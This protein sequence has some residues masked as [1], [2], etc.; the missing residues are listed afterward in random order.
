MRR[1]LPAL[2]AV[3]EPLALL[4]VGAAAGLTLLPDA[5]SYDD[6]DHHVPGRDRGAP[7]LTCTPTGPVPLPTRVPVVAWR[8]GIDLNPLD[9][10]DP[11]RRDVA[12]VSAVAREGDRHQRLHG[13][14]ATAARHRPPSTAGTSSTTSPGSPPTPR[15]ARPWSSITRRSWP[16]STPTGAAPSPPRYATST[17][18]GCPTRPRRRR[19]TTPPHTRVPQRHLRPDPRR[20][21]TARIHRPPRHLDRVGLLTR[22]RPDLVGRA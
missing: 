19:T 11:R 16:T 12:G 13:A 20:Q 7:R 6:A 10:A 5:Y 14:L 15:P 3:P 22:T 18:H 2:A 9:P 8:A 21:R 4:E 17:P 1:S